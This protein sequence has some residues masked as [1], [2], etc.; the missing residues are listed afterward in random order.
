VG[1]GHTGFLAAAAQVRVSGQRQSASP[2]LV[3]VAR[4]QPCAA[5]GDFTI[6]A[7][8]TAVADNAPLKLDFY[9]TDK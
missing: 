4:V 9:G 7:T 8:C 1:A 6:T 2:N 3:R 5:T